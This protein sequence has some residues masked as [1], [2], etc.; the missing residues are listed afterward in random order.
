MKKR[1]FLLMLS[2]VFV[3]LTQSQSKETRFKKQISKFV[4][5][6]KNI[7]N[8]D[9][10]EK[11]IKNHIERL[12]DITSNREIKDLE[13]RKEI[14]LL[15]ENLNYGFSMVEGKSSQELNFFADYMESEFNQAQSSYHDNTEYII[16]GVGILVGLLIYL[17]VLA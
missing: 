16:Y 11:I 5:K 3:S 12:N 8:R 17:L 15:I 13:E 14:T 4:K 2:L 7:K 1:I 9:K 10:K 6:V